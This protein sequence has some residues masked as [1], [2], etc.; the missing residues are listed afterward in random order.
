MLATGY[1]AAAA[2]TRLKEAGAT[3]I[4]FVCIMTVPEGLQVML[5]THPDV[6]IYTCVID[7]GTR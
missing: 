6:A 7:R 4:R 2:V 3:Q 5:D 1:S